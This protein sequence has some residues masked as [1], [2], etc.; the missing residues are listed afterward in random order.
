[1]G[2]TVKRVEKLV[3]A[4][5][6]TKVTDGGADGVRGLMLAVE[7]KTSAAWIFRFQRDGKVYHMG[8]GS[9][10]DVPLASARAKARREREKLADGV[11]P[12][13]LKRA[14]RATAAAAS[15]RTLTFKQAAE[16]YHEAHAAAWTNSKHADEFLS[17]LERW[18]YPI[19]GGM[20][21][22]LVG[23]DEVL[24]CLEQRLP[25]GEPGTFWHG[26]TITA[27]RTRGRIERVLDFCEARGYRPAGTPN[28]ARW[29]GF[30]D[31][32][33][34]RP[35][36]VAPVQ[37][38]RSL[39][40][41]EVPALMS[42]LAADGSV[43]AQAVRFIIMTAARMNEAVGG[44]TWA[45]IDLQNALWTVPAHRMKARREHVVPLSPQVVALLKAL[46]TEADNQH[47]FI[48]SKTAGTAITGT[49]VIAALRDA[50][51]TA[52]M[53]GF[54]SSFSTWAH[55]RSNF[56]NHA[57]E[58]SLAHAVGNQVE[59]AYR[60]TDLAAQRKKLMEQWGRFCTT[61]PA[62]KADV[63]PLRSRSN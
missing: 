24:R 2:L 21:C 31:N 20:D 37:H 43:A 10:R 19:M 38:M 13:A 44:A 58:L 1:M 50:G 22:A 7:S 25:N 45:E 55:E 3:R 34:P 18:V 11:N 35:R 6:R 33:L 15:A 39:G 8:I 42:K 40:Y 14:Q 30:L 4:G 63:L 49:S 60:R 5:V 28:P 51:C 57:I 16:R 17:S 46:P 56:S 59:R 48:S 53:H 27:D 52:T 23:K 9:A 36:K 41:G 32:L 47:V 12:L 29:R 61:P 62:A 54:R 26:R